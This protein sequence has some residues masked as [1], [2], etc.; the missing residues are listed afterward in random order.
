MAR[1]LTEEHRIFKEVF[2][3]YVR[4]E[5]VPN[6]KTWEEQRL[7]PRSVWKACGAQGFLCPW[8]SAE[9]GGGGADFGYSYVIDLE[10]ARSGVNMML[11]LHNDIVVPYLG[12][13]G[14]AEQKR[15]WLPGCVS[16]D[17]LAAVAMT[18]PGTGSDLQSVSTTARRYGD[19][20]VI[21]GQKIF[22]SNGMECDVVIVVCR[23]AK[24]AAGRN[25]LSL[26]VVEDGT[27]GFVKARRLDKMGM[28]SNGTAE[29]VFADCR[30]PANNLL[31]EENNAFKYL[32][33]K[34]QVERIVQSLMG[35]GL[36]E[37]VLELSLEYAKT[38]QAFG[39]PIG[40]FQHNQ[41]K[42][43]EMATEVALAKSFLD[44][45][46]QDHLDGEDVVTKVSMAK[47]WISEMVNRVAY[48]GV[49]LH[50]GYGYMEEFEI[51]RLYR[52]ARMQTIAAGTTE[53]MKQ[54][55]AK[56]LGL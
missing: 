10:I 47:W 56:R 46:V 2:R 33:S 37:R 44:D 22:I 42:L 9:Y 55:I 19:D 32:M 7:V 11:G 23:T 38:R 3:R 45:L 35:V 8:V 16:G 48:Q 15:R 13:Y 25:A 34:L 6:W 27:P 28:H 39:K 26:I 14:N 24:D 12:T 20:Y 40:S 52:D 36:A 5:L 51:C 54:T 4:A 53:I 43:A 41:F 18:E 30:V 50:G 29:L 1:F 21:N 17:I 31:G 49:Q